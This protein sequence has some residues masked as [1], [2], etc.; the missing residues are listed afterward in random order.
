[1]AQGVTGRRGARGAPG[2]RGS[3][4]LT[5]PAGPPGPT[6]IEGIRGL[7]GARGPTGRRG[8]TTKASR[9]PTI[10][11]IEHLDR[12]MSA[13]QKALE[14]QLIRIAQIQQQLDELRAHVGAG[15]R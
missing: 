8:V 12:E 9:K 11:M 3:V 14:T 2:Q 10:R 15:G 7:R 1:M 5:G 6:G 4:G 13:V